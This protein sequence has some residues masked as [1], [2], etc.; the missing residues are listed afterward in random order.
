MMW[1][2]PLLPP[3]HCKALVLLCFSLRIYAE[4]TR[5]RLLS[6]RARRFTDKKGLMRFDFWLLTPLA[7]WTP[8]PRTRDFC[9]FDA[10][11][12]L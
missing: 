12:I 2:S 1:L 3:L 11:E 6:R 7:A 4:L 5:G 8:A 10:A 9:E